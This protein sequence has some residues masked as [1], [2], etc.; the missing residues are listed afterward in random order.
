MKICRSTSPTF[1]YTVPDENSIYDY[2]GLQGAQFEGTIK[3]AVAD[4]Y[5]AYLPP[6]LPGDYVLTF[7]SEGPDGPNKFI[8]DVTYN[9]TVE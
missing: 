2:F 5:W 3:P 7:H 8:L 4:G 1:Q 9:L 6:P